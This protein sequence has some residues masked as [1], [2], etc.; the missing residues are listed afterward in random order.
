[1]PAALVDLS[2]VTLD[3]SVTRYLE[4]K[5]ESTRKAYE[6]CLKRFTKFSGEPFKQFLEQI[7]E[8]LRANLDRPIHEKVRPGEDAI[9]GFIE[10]HKEAGYSNY[11]TLQAIG[12]I[13]NILKYYGIAIGFGFIDTPPARPMKENDKHEW[14]LDQ[15]RQF[16]E[17]AEYIRDKAYIIFAFQSGLSIGD[18]LALN[19]D[20]IRRE[21]E[22][23]ITPLAIEGYREKNNV[24][25]KTFIG[26]DAVTYLHLYLQSRPD[27]QPNDPIFTLLGTNERATAGCIQK[28]LRDYA[29]KLNF[30]YE[31]DLENGYNPARPHSLR[32][33]FRSRLTGKMDGELIE[34]F[35]AHELGQSRRTYMNQPLDELR[36]IYSNYEHLLA[37]E[38]TSKE[39]LEDL[40]PRPLPEEAMTLIKN[41]ET[42]VSTLSQ[43]NTSLERRFDRLDR[44]VKLWIR[45]RASE[46]ELKKMER[47]LDEMDETEL[48]EREEQERLTGLMKKGKLGDQEKKN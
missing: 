27:I 45:D 21:F 24:P 43:K 16:V 39:A 32:S 37:I 33:A 6:K 34:F 40:E 18:I 19:Y 42:T 31:V 35:M 48:Q 3:E 44:F 12:A 23:E 22:A 9:R 10:W 17:V 41:L 30:L 20:D 36:E 14:T 1:M 46:D 38:K 47:I 25:I 11:S 13:Q 7:E 8:Q 15:I 29:Q 28:K 26:H 5:G 4:T 2:S